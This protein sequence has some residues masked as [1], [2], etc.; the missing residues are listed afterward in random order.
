MNAVEELMVAQANEY[1]ARNPVEREVESNYDFDTDSLVIQWIKCGHKATISRVLLDLPMY[2]QAP[3]LIQE[4][5]E[6]RCQPCADIKRLANG[7][8]GIYAKM[9]G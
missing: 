4:F 7:M 3:G 8:P 6:K 9:R 2:A 5:V 1:L